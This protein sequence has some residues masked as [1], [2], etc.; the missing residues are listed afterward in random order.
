[1]WFRLKNSNRNL[2]NLN[3]VDSLV[4]SV[5]DPELLTVSF[6]EGETQHYYYSSP[7]KRR[8]DE[9]RLK[10]TMGNKGKRGDMTGEIKEYFKKHQ[11]T[12]VTLAIVILIDQFLFEGRFRDKIK[13]I[14]EKLINRIDKQLIGDSDERQ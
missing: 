7:K 11:D 2:I 9:K 14:M 1:M 8:M 12:F 3:N 5:V 10:Q 6:K 4:W 13:N